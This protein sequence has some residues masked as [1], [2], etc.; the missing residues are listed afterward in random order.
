M[1]RND[2]DNCCYCNLAA[3]KTVTKLDDKDILHVSFHNSIYEVPY[4]VAVD[5]QMASIVVAIRGT[6]SGHDALTDLAA[7]TDPIDGEGLPQGWT[8][9]RGMLQTANFLL[10][11]LE[12][13]G[14]LQQAFAQYPN[15]R[16]VITGNLKVT[17]RHVSRF[18]QVLNYILKFWMLKAKKFASQELL[19]PSSKLRF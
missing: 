6:L 13:N 19:I 8:A 14:V 15:Y 5:H 9:H 16:L 3:L 11:Q 12:Q 10:R 7:V 17:V 2:A 4:F 18:N 1:V